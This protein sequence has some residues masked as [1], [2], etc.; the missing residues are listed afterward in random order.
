MITIHAITSFHTVR[1]SLILHIQWGITFLVPLRMG[2]MV[3][4]RQNDKPPVRIPGGCWIRFTQ[5]LQEWIPESLPP[6]RALALRV[7]VAPGYRLV[8]PAILSKALIRPCLVYPLASFDVSGQWLIS[9]TAASPNEVSIL[10][11]YYT[12]VERESQERI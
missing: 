7:V 12:L 6:G 5:A 3:S 9:H 10:H 11:G 1:A 8:H 4:Q 2:Q